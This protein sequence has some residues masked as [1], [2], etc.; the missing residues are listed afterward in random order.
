MDLAKNLD[1]NLDVFNNLVLDLANFKEVFTHEH[2]VV[3]FLN[4]L[5]DK[6][7]NIKISLKYGRDTITSNEIMSSFRSKNL[8]LKK[9]KNFQ[10]VGVFMLEGDPPIKVEITRA[11]R[12]TV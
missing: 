4:F 5:S 10:V 9:E 3:I 2:H 1:D 11:V 8:K 12:V 7:K 6:Y